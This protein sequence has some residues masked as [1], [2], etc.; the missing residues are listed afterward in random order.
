MI[1]YPN[2]KINLG[3]NI[4][5]RRAD[6]Y[7]DIETVFYP[8]DLTDILE[9]VPAKGDDAT[10][11]TYGR[12][13]DCPV[14]KNLVMKAFRLMQRECGAPLADI[15]LDKII[16][17]GAGLGGGSADA[18]FT[19]LAVNEMFGLGV[20]AERLAA[21]AATIGADCPF[22]IYNRP[23]MAT[24]IGDVLTDVDLTLR[25]YRMLLVKSD[26]I[27]VPTALAYSR[28]TP[29]PSDTPITEI[30]RRP[31]AEWQGALKNDFEPSVFAS[32]PQLAE[33]KAEMLRHGA[34]YAAMSGSGS[35]IFGIFDSANMADKADFAK[36]GNIF[37]IQ[38]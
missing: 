29:K 14:E 9:V 15:Y 5:S 20:P 6:G 2:A 13:I 34:L 31:I 17:D 36:F 21:L 37:D 4:V 16:P 10:L 33:V 35:S 12:A 11:T 7:H 32:F 8:I 28:V 26:E 25:G 30:L 1:S 27:S 19:M 23:M 24:G 3:L 38:L 22:F 18:A